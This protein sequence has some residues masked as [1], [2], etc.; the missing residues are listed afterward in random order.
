MKR[1]KL[2]ILS[3]KNYKDLDLINQDH[4]NFDPENQGRK[5][6]D[7]RNRKNHSSYNKN[8]GFDN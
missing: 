8:S 7:Q 4:K 3:E 5:V 6:H 2:K 1:S